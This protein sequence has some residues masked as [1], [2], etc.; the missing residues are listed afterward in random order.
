MDKGYLCGVFDSGRSDV[1]DFRFHRLASMS[2]RGGPGGTRKP[3]HREHHHF[4]CRRMAVV[5]VMSV[6]LS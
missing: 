4:T 6:A 5:C 1:H 2:P 3:V